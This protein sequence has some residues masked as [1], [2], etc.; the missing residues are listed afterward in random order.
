M[1]ALRRM[2]SLSLI[3]AAAGSGCAHLVETKTIEKFST[4][5][6]KQ[7]LDG[8]KAST[9]DEFAGRALRTAEALEDF[10]IRRIPDGKHSVVKV[11]KLSGN[12]KR[13]TV[14]VGE[15]KK[16]VFYELTKNS[17]GKWVVDDIYLRQ[18]K[19]GVE[20]YKAVSEQ[21]DLLLTVREFLDAWDTGERADVLQGTTPELRT[22][23]ET[24][25]PAYLAQLTRKITSGRKS[26][27][28]QRPQAQLSDDV[29]VVR[30]PRTAGELLLTLELQNAHWRVSDVLVKS[31]EE[32]DGLPSL[33]REAL[34]IEHGLK[35]L[36]AYERSDRSALESLCTADFYEGSLSMGNLKE[37]ALPSSLLID[38]DLSIALTGLRADLTLQN[39][40]EIV[41]LTLHR[42]QEEDLE[43]APRFHVS[44]VTI[45]DIASEQKMRLGALFTARAMGEFYL[46][47]LSQRD[48]GKLRHSSTKDFSTRVWQKLNEATIASAPLEPF[49]GPPGEISKIQ[50]N[51]PLARLDARA[52]DQQVELVL[53]EESGRFLVDDIL[54]S[55]P[56]RPNTVKATLELIIPVRK[57]ATGIALGRAPREQTLA[58]EMLQETSS[59]D[60]NRMVW[61]QTEFVPASGLSADTFLNAPLKS[62]TMSDGQ[63]IVQLGDNRFGAVVTMIKEHD[64]FAIDEVLLIAGPHPADRITMKHEMRTQLARGL[65]QRPGGVVQASGTRLHGAPP[66]KLVHADFQ[67]EQKAPRQ[68][69][70]PRELEEL[71]EA[72]PIEDWDELGA[73]QTEPAV[74]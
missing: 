72:Q 1:F 45:N 34:A 64:R 20:A 14:A 74:E 42:S 53:K 49:D 63:V 6:K 71:D 38:H 59:R 37:V 25:P 32:A 15:A 5:L 36:A 8:L 50:F 52:G 51:G 47:A 22:A 31:K 26:F 30:I 54:W 28:S 58:L 18:K 43:E 68:T 48:V 24:L 10:E 4:Q 27:K 2:W 11:E 23:L 13:V 65:A 67:E 9:S 66:S 70:A 56:G 35:F 29:A 73:V 3:L 21:M 57:F 60:F 62:L 17:T 39:D 61:T 46:Q 16:E 19:Q 69:D 41:Q 33:Y 55:L 44:N 40:R 7:D 12:H